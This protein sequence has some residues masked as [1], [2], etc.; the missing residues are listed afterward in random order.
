MELYSRIC[1]HTRVFHVPPQSYVDA[2]TCL[3]V[4][5]VV[6]DCQSVLYITKIINF[7]FTSA[8]SYSLRS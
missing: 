1:R 2:T 8:S 5:E 6:L 3:T 7:I 4:C